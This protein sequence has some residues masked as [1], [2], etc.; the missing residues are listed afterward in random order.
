[1]CLIYH[2]QTLKAI[3]GYSKENLLAIWSS[4]PEAWMKKD[5]FKK[6]LLKDFA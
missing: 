1:M 4:D 2:S 6:W 3:R 5:I